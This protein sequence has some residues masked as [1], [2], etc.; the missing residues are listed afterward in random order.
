[1]HPPKRGIERFTV[2]SR[3]TLVVRDGITG[4]I[5]AVRTTKNMAVYGTFNVIASAVCNDPGTNITCNKLGLGSGP[6]VE[7]ADTEL[8]GETASRT[9]GRFSHDENAPQWNLSFSVSALAATIS[10]RQAGI[11]TSLT[12]GV[13]YLKATFASLTVNSQDV[14]NVAWLQSLASA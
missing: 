13:L 11:F 9:I 12:G 4:K 3:V 10:I 2:A 14:L 1:M 8:S 6:D 7:S 5:K